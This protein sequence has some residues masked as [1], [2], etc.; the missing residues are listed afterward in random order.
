VRAE[1]ESRRRYAYE[2]L[3]AVGLNPAWP[4]GAF[5][6]WVPVWESGH[7]GRVFADGLLRD[8]KV[9]VTP[10]EWFGPSGAG[11]VRLSYA[12]DGRLHEGINRLGDYVQTLHSARPE[13]LPIRQAA[14]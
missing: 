12:D 3:R 2:R 6:L 9:R 10:G 13:P 4:R 1:F 11:H 7:G 14:A 8:Q 5:F